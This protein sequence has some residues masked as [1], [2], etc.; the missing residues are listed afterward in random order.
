MPMGRDQ[1]GPSGE[2]TFHEKPYAGADSAR[3]AIREPTPDQERL[4]IVP[5]R[6]RAG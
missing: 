2:G 4:V 6:Y 5:P 1:E 3:A